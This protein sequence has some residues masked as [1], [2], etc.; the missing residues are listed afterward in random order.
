[1]VQRKREKFPLTV[2]L[3][4][5]NTKKPLYFIAQIQDI[6]QR[7]KAEEEFIKVTNIKSE[8]LSMV[9]HEL[10]TPLTAI[11][12][13]IS[14]ILE[15][16]LGDLNSQQNKLLSASKKN[17]DRLAR[18]I[19]DVLDFQKIESGKMTWNIRQNDINETVKEA[20]ESMLPAIREKGLQLIFTCMENLPKIQ[21]DK[22]KIF[23]VVIN[24]LNNAIKFTERGDII[25]ETKREGKIIHVKVRD[26][27]IGIKKEDLPRLF[28]SF[29]QLGR[30]SERKVGGTGLGLSICKKIIIHHKGKI[31]AKSTFGRGTTVHFTLPINV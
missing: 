31:W 1:M 19:N 5:D 26:T 4:L 23:Q 18:L 8:F 27:G 30:P 28:E 17:V 20:G 16:L 3:L 7:K 13:G 12:E 14:I 21:F 2:S 11:K 15:G 24:L 6:S 9:S 10:R 29:V 25:I 22:D